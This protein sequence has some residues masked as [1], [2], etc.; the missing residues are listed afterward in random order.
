[1]SNELEIITGL[2]A[3]ILAEMKL[4]RKNI[5]S[6]LGIK[7]EE[8]IFYK[9]GKKEV[10][11]PDDDYEVYSTAMGIYVFMQMVRREGVK[12][13]IETAEKQLF[14]FKSFSFEMNG[15]KKCY[16]DRFLFPEDDLLYK[17]EEYMTAVDVKV[18]PFKFV[19]NSNNIKVAIGLIET[20]T[21]K[22]FDKRDGYYTYTQ[23]MEFE[24]K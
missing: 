4:L 1:M 12:K 21:G 3:E 15:R 13:M 6:M 22:K 23:L 24:P 17:I 11:I 20:G 7:K 5:E 16:E 10:F 2:C 8:L 18:A 19:Y 14:N 9:E